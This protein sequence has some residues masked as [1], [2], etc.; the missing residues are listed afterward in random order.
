MGWE[1]HRRLKTQPD[2]TL[3]LIALENNI[4]QAVMIAFLRKRD[5]WLWQAHARKGFRF[6]KLMFNALKNWSKS[7]MRKKIRMGVYEKK[8][9]FQRKWGFKPCHWDK[10]IMELK[11]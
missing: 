9:L 10:N 1:L 11:L 4:I 3:C 8:E 2:D 7:K 6:S 5:T